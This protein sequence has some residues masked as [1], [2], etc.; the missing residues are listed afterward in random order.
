MIK[1][2]VNYTD[3]RDDADP[4]YPGGKAIDAPTEESIE[5]TP[6]KAAWMNDIN[7]FRQAAFVKAF[8][9]MSGVNN[10]PD[11]T[12]ESDTLKALE[13]LTKDAIAPKAPLESPALTGT[14]TAPTAS[15]ETNNTQ[16]AT[17]AF[18]KKSI[19]DLVNSSPASLDTLQELAAALGNDPNFSTTM[20]NAIAERA[21]LESP[22]LIGTPTA[23]TAPVE[24]NNTQLATTAFVKNIL[25]EIVYPIG[26]RYTQYPNDPS[27]LKAKLPGHWE[28]W[29][30]RAELYELLPE[31][32][33]NTLFTSVPAYWTINETIAANQYRVWTPM[34]VST[35]GTRRIIKSNKSVTAAPKDINPIDWDDLSYLT[36]VERIELQEWTDPDLTI[37][38][39]VTYNGNQYRIVGVLTLS[40]LFI[41]YDGGN[42]PTFITGGVAR[43]TMRLLKG[44]FGAEFG[45]NLGISFT[46]SSGVFSRSG[47]AGGYCS[48]GSGS[49]NR[50][51]SFDSSLAALSGNEF[52]PLTISIRYW[53]RIA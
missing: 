24:I 47:A 34:G 38:Q 36:C 18:V 46:T 22:A 15:V 17:T 2:D 3:Y 6:I 7:G 27:P 5:G 26:K 33:Y 28:L 44:S 32:T 13:K 29:N 8:G 48:A 20:I 53:R 35:S 50:T 41:S 25:S 11:S 37:G 30:E 49:G 52:S 42:R 31:A 16:L 43:D 21:P 4:H 51:M 10:K 9:S 39:S 45:S 12:E 14:P 40:G 23:P 19:A 1:I